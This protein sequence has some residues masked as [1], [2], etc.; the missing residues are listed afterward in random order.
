MH[1]NLDRRVEVLVKV[2]SPALKKTLLEILALAFADNCSA[3]TLDSQG[4]WTQLHRG[5][6]EPCVSFQTELMRRAIQTS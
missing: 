1:R 6:D 5:D 2:E 4:G 3:W